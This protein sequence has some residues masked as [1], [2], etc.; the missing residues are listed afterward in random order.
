MKNKFIQQDAQSLLAGQ[1][2]N[3]ISNNGLSFLYA[4]FIVKLIPFA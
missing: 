4:L 2:Y 1:Q 3:V